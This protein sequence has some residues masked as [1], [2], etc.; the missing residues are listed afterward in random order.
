M[1]I[2]EYQKYCKKIAIRLTDCRGK[3]SKVIRVL[4][5]FVYTSLTFL[6]DSERSL[7]ASVEDRNLVKSK[8]DETLDDLIRLYESDGRLLQ[9][10]CM[11]RI[12]DDLNHEVNVIHIVR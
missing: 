5:E 11:K 4:E 12:K 2:T 3:K 10:Y 1:T 7:K 8:I 9:V 6:N